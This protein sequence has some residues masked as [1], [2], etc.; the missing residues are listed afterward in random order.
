MTETFDCACG[1]SFRAET[2]QELQDKV[3]FHLI[4][5]HGEVVFGDPLAVGNQMEQPMEGVI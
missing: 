3:R 5:D 4:L 1:K 2:V